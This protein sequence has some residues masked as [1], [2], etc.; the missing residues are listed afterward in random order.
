[1]NYSV[2][3]LVAALSGGST[4]REKALPESKDFASWLS[5]S[6]TPTQTSIM[7]SIIDS[8]KDALL[9]K[10]LADKAVMVGK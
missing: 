8:T 1:M 6:Y 4:F 3:D 5:S 7:A 10:A 9:V 2:S